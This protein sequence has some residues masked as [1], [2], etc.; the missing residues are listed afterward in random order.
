MSL[1][2][3]VIRL[4]EK[5]QRTRDSDPY[6]LVGL[7]YD[8]HV[9]MLLDICREIVADPAVDPAERDQC[10]AE[11]AKIEDEIMAKWR[12]HL[13]T[14]ADT[15]GML[16]R[17]EWRGPQGEEYVE[18]LTYCGEGDLHAPNVMQRRAALRARPDIQRLLADAACADAGGI[19][20]FIG[21][22]FRGPEA[23]PGMSGG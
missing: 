7:T 19:P 13:R 22:V 12:G 9:V 8:E 20:R 2:S 16:W 14:P 23:V 6:G 18:P 17:R 21:R 5:A 11:I 10:D 1:S 15:S 4:E 3:R